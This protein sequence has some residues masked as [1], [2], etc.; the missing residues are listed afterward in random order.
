M[1]RRAGAGPRLPRHEDRRRQDPQTEPYAEISVRPGRAQVREMRPDRRRGEPGPAGHPGWFAGAAG[2]SRR[3]RTIR[4]PYLSA[5]SSRAGSSRPS[6]LRCRRAMSRGAPV[7]GHPGRGDRPHRREM[8]R[9][10][11]AGFCPGIDPVRAIDTLA[12]IWVKSV[13]WRPG[14]V[15]GSAG[16]GTAVAGPAAR[17][18]FD[19]SRQARQTCGPNMAATSTQIVT[20]A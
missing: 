18:A 3:Q 10:Q 12:T 19:R 9:A 8:R 4:K 14:W 15:P 5:A 7:A 16:A 20:S 17:L 13:Y 11:A 6:G 2:S 1:A